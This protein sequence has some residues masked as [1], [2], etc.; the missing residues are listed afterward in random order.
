MVIRGDL[1]LCLEV[2]TLVIGPTGASPTPG[3]PS[4]Q[5]TSYVRVLVEPVLPTFAPEPVV[6]M[7][8]PPQITSGPALPLSLL[9]LLLGAWWNWG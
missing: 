5:P 2:T 7:P 6:D 1:S 3:M 8:A 4:L 9:L